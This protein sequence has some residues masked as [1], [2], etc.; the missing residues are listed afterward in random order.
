MNDPEPDLLLE[1]LHASDVGKR[2]ARKLEELVAPSA[3]GLDER[4]FRAS[5]GAGAGRSRL[6]G[7]RIARACIQPEEPAPQPP[8]L[9]RRLAGA[10]ELV[11]DH[12]GGAA[13]ASLG[14]CSGERHLGGGVCGIRGDELA[15]LRHRLLPPACIFE[16]LGEEPTNEV[17][18]RGDHGGCS[19]RRD[20]AVPT[21][22]VGHLVPPSSSW[23]PFV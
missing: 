10:L 15:A 17:I 20:P 6:G 12:L 22:H 21:C 7:V 11:E 14:E 18:G 23:T 16:R 9:D 19:Q 13:I 3:V 1:L 5:C 8:G 2:D 4:R